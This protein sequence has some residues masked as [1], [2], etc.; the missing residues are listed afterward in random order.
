MKNQWGVIVLTVVFAAILPQLFIAVAEQTRPETKETE[1]TQ[2]VTEPASGSIR[3]LMGDR[4]VEMDVEDYL[5]GVI[6]QEMPKDFSFEAKKAQ[7]VVARTY[8]LRQCQTE[9]H[10][11]AVCI[12]AS[13]CQAYIAPEQYLA[14]GG[15]QQ[16]VEQA[17]AAAKQTCGQVL[18]Y[19]GALIEATFFSCSGGRTEDAVAVWGSDVPYLQSVESPGEENATHFVDTVTFTQSEFAQALSIQPDF[20]IGSVKRTEGE[21]V[22]SIQIGGKDFTGVELRRLLNLSSTCFYLT[23][24]GENITVTTRGFGHRVGM[25]QYGADAMGQAG[26]SYHE[27]LAHYYPGTTLACLEN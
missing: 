13:C 20:K 19:D 17:R 10:G 6:L 26:K 2:A 7:A 16:A 1:P 22:A 11:G 3:V 15:Q 12:T 18:R 25:S 4:S 8:A 5:T 14:K 24:I 23:Q 9:K 27:I 21:G